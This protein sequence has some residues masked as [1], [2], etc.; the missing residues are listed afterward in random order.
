MKKVI[1]FSVVASLFVFTACKKEFT[2]TVQSNNE[3]WGS[4]TGSGTY[5]KGSTVSIAAVAKSGYKFVSW[6]DN[7]TDNPRS[8]TVNANET[9]IATFAQE[10]GGGGGETPTGLDI[11]TGIPCIDALAND[12]VK[13]QGGT[14]LMGAVSGDTLAY[15]DEKPQHSVTLSDFYICKYEVTQELWQAVMGS[16]PTYGG[17][18]T[19]EYGKGDKY[20]AYRIS[21]NDCDT[22]I[23]RL[24]AKTGLNF[25]MPTEAEWEY[26]ARGGNKSQG[27]TYAGSN[28]IG[29]VA[30]YSSNSDS[31]THPVM[32]KTVNELGLYDM[33]GNVWEWCSDW[34]SST[35]YTESAGASN[36]KG[37]STGSNR[38]FR[39]G[40]WTTDA[41]N[42]RVSYRSFNAPFNHYNNIGFRLAL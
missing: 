2:V 28:T 14:F 18:W 37:P 33:T 27:Y 20:P 38:V 10:S 12:M 24:N 13:V 9:Y 36:P 26:A 15:D 42:C 29:D 39:G 3:L 32:Q 5:A 30:W 1:L 22:F 34:F 11:H 4:V 6:Q 8:I 23:Q 21:W 40:G 16:T 19:A 17:G 41:S 7:N 35:Y 31:K 25:R